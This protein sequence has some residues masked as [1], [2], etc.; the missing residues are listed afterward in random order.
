MLRNY[1]FRR[2]KSKSTILMRMV[3]AAGKA[4]GNVVPRQNV[5]EDSFGGAAIGVWTRPVKDG[6]L[7]GGSC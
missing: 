7:L 1:W 3:F 6:E 5:E 2:S 4:V